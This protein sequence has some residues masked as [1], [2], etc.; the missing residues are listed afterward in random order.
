MHISSTGHS[1]IQ[2]VQDPGVSVKFDS[3][4]HIP[5]GFTG[6]VT[7]T[8][9]LTPVPLRTSTLSQVQ[10]FF[11]SYIILLSLFS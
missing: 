11:E 9:T 5:T 10:R 1:D 6:D 8:L 3:D 2:E 7:M 4:N